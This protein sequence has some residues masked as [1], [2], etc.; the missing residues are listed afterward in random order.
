MIK[1]FRHVGIVVADMNSQLRFY[2]D[3]LGLEIY[4]NETEIGKFFDTIL[5]LK[6]SCAKIYKLG[7]NNKTI[8][9]LIEFAFYSTPSH[10]RLKKTGIT[11]FAITVD[12]LDYLYD[13]YEG[14]IKFVSEP[15]ISDD[16]KHKVCFC[17]DFEG[18]YIELV[19]ILK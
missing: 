2:K 12:N 13:N 8:V 18:N 3:L 14:V 7:R 9:E 17:Q 19:E 1:N 10:K 5:G 6:K 15:Q 16:G 4:Y 11:H